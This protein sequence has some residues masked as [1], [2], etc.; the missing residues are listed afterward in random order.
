MKASR[1]VL[2]ALSIVPLLIA[3]MLSAFTLFAVPP[4]AP[5]RLPYIA[6]ILGVSTLLSAVLLWGFIGI[7][8]VQLASA[9]GFGAGSA[10][11]GAVAVGFVPPL[12]LTFHA[13]FAGALIVLIARLARRTRREGQ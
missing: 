12:R 11:I 7:T 10:A 1:A 4:G 3:V 6:I 9:I 8:R 5:G 13:A 2:T